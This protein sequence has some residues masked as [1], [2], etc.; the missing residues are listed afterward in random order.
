MI[1]WNRDG[2]IDAV[3][4]LLTLELLEEEDHRTGPGCC[5][6]MLAVFVLVLSTAG[7]LLHLCL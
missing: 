6:P 3:D 2:K 7:A 4:T 1:D 5:G